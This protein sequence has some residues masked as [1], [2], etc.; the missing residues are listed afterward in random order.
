MSYCEGRETR[1]RNGKLTSDHR[2]ESGIV[3][4]SS[5]AVGSLS[6]RHE[7]GVVAERLGE[8]GSSVVNVALPMTSISNH[9]SGV[10]IE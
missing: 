5:C 8:E 6:T 3:L 10:S 4:L 9:E 7:L 1:T 2:L